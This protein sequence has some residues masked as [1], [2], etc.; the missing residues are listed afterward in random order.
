MSG[1]SDGQARLEPSGKSK[2]RTGPDTSLQEKA[3]TGGTGTGP[4]RVKG[5]PGTRV[6][7]HNP[8]PSLGRSLAKIPLK[9]KTFQKIIRDFRSKKFGVHWDVF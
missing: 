4:E 5:R 8:G 9:K 3:R 1:K 6:V 2:I 7:G